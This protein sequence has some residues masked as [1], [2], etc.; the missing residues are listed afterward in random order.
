MEEEIP[1]HSTSKGSKPAPNQLLFGVLR[2]LRRA[3][4]FGW[5]D[6]SLDAPGPIFPAL[7]VVFPIPVL[8]SASAAL[9]WCFVLFSC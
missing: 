1:L 3:G 2:S 6:P 7:V 8:F 5:L 4:T 9:L